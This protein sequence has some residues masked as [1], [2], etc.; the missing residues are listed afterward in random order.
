MPG[1]L[2]VEAPE[3]GHHV[4]GGRRHDHEAAVAVDESDDLA[5][6]REGRRFTQPV[7]VV[8]QQDEVGMVS[9]HPDERVGEPR[10]GHEDALWPRLGAIG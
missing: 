6:H 1:E 3:A 4:R 9:A 5:E 7:G 10:V 8:D 2:D